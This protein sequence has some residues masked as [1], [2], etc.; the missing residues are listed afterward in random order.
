MTI[1][2]RAL[3]ARAGECVSHPAVALA[4]AGFARA[5]HRA[6]VESAAREAEVSLKRFIA[7]FAEEV[8]MTPKRYLR[9][10]RFQR[11]IA[12]VHRAPDVDWME[13]VERNGY[14]D[15]PHFIREFKEFSGLT[16]SDYFRRRG[17]Y[18]QH[19]PLEA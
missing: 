18:L 2:F 1:L 16:P 6:T 14:Y 13:V 8:G 10:A 7:L 19:V 17:P 5:P 3:A 4:L 15:Q 9:V 12:S 11:V